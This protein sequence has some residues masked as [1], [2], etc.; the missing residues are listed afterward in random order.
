MVGGV[1]VGGVMPGGVMECR[2]WA[3]ADRGAR[4]EVGVMVRAAIATRAMAVSRGAATRTV[5]VV[6]M[7]VVMVGVVMVA[8]TEIPRG[9]GTPIPRAAGR[10]S[11]EVATCVGPDNGRGAGF[12]R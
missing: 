4:A 6:V 5:D 10:L 2:L 1:M 11:H 8:G 9:T 12:A 3:T 7:E